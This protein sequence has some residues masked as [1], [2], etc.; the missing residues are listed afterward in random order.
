MYSECVVEIYKGIQNLD[1]LKYTR[2]DSMWNGLITEHGASLKPQTISLHW[3]RRYILIGFGDFTTCTVVLFSL[4][5]T[6]AWQSSR[7]AGWRIAGR[8]VPFAEIYPLTSRRTTTVCFV[9]LTKESCRKSVNMLSIKKT[10]KALTRKNRTDVVQRCLDAVQGTEY[11][12]QFNDSD[13]PAS[14][15]LWNGEQYF[16]VLET[17]VWR[18]LEMLKL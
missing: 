7:K 15:L 9:H 16:G 17:F 18:L 4:G 11:R 12:L 3:W 6:L 2:N 13:R 10:F 1:Y 14:C 8:I 5:S